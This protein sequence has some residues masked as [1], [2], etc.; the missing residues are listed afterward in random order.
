MLL[1]LVALFFAGPIAEIYVL[2]RAGEAFGAGPVVAACIA[3]AI[4]GGLILRLQGL[5]ALNSARRDLDQGRPPVEAAADGVFL[6]IAAPFLLTPGFITDTLGFLLLIP[7]LRRFIAR[8][9]LARL[10][11]S[12]D[13]GRTTLIV[14]RIER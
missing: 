13:E 9:M 2:L 3:T 1:F 8:R 10:R 11:R 14:R 6:L 4:L 5:A 12:V 7:P